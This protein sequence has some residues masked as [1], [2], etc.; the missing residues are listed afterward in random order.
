MSR[1]IDLAIA[2]V[3]DGGGPFG[4]VV[5]LDGNSIGEGVNRVTER[6]DPTAH[7]EVE[8]IRDACR[9]TGNFA[10]T[11]AAV[12]A[13]CEPCPLCLAAT[14][15]ARVDRIYF[16]ATRADAAAAGFDDAR[17]H[18]ALTAA[19]GAWN[20]RLAQLPHPRSGEPFDAWRANDDRILY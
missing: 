7:A 8:A 9:N 20:E 4:A 2:N 18:G 1:A 15:W 17:F 19:P 10:L 5:V 13:S 11:G 6:L 12:Y 14:L 3:A 16:A